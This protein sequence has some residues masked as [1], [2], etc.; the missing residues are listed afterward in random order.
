MGFKLIFN[1]EL[2]SYRILTL[3]NFPYGFLIYWNMHS[4]SKNRATPDNKKQSYLKFLVSFFFFFSKM[5]QKNESKILKRMIKENSP[6]LVMRIIS[7]QY[8]VICT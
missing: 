8:V 3:I 4:C 7:V 1:S 6:E 2:G 5:K